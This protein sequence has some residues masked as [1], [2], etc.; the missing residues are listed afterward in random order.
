MNHLPV[1][2]PRCGHTV[3]PRAPKPLTKRQHE[4]MAYLRT[5]IT[6]HGFAPSHEEIAKA[7]GYRTLSTVHEHLSHL[8]A[9]GHITRSFN[10]ARAIALVG[11]SS[12]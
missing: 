12:R 11:E 10:S 2:C 5:Y 6:E 4:V 8:E 1:Q 7:F 3:T 9:K